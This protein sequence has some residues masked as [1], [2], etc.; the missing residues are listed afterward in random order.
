MINYCMLNCAR[1]FYPFRVLYG[2]P[3]N[4]KQLYLGNKMEHVIKVGVVYVHMN[5][6]LLRCLK[7]EVA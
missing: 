5:I 3:N 2:N 7:E 4:K 6:R 1:A